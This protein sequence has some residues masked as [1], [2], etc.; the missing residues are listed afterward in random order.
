[1]LCTSQ[2]L[3]AGPA[4]ACQSRNAH[5]QRCALALTRTAAD[6][7]VAAAAHLARTAT[8]S[9][10]PTARGMQPCRAVAAP[11]DASREVEGGSKPPL[12]VV[13]AGAGIGGLV[14]AVGLLK[15]GFEVTVL[16]RDMTA[17][18][19]EGKYRGPIQIQSN[20]LGAL[21][22]LDLEVA[23][24][25][26]DVGCITGDRINGLC[27]GVTGD[28]YIKF[29]TFHPAVDMGLPVTRVISRV[30]L[31]EILA[32]ACQR[33]AGDGVIT[34]SVNIVD[35]EQ[36]PDPVTGK[37]VVTA[38]AEDGRRF[39]GDLLIGADGI[40]SKVRRK[41]LGDSEPNYSQYTCYTG[42]S[43]FTPADIDVVG[44]RVFLGNGKYFVSSDVGGGKMQWYAFHKEPADGTDAPGRCKHRLMEIFGSWTHL[45]TDLIKATKE[46]DI[47]RRDIY[48]RP[49]IFKWADGRVALLGDS[50]H[51]MQPNLGQG[52]CMAIE[53]A[54]QL[55]LDLCKEADA[56]QAEA[57]KGQPRDMDVEGVLSGYTGKRVV[58]AATIHGMAGMAAYMA[59]TY[60]AYLG[61]GLGPLSWITKFKIPH[62]GRVVGQVVMKATMP[63][64]MYGILGG[65]RKSLESSDRVA[66]CHLADQP[67]G[68]AE[69][70]F[71]LYMRDDDALLRAS[72][73]HWILTPAIEEGVDEEALHREF[74]AAK[75]QSPV[76]T[77]AGLTVGSAASCDMV[78]DSP[79][80]AAKHARLHQC[81]MG[82]YH[83]TDL[84]SEHGTWVNDRKLA[85]NAAFRLHP[86]D[87][88]RFGPPREGAIDFVVRMVHRSLLE[89][90]GRHGSYDR[91]AA[92]RSADERSV[93]L[94]SK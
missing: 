65:Y 24:R 3:A 1:M 14:L 68:F 41:M 30:T 31:Q 8:R 91:R 81:E 22:A 82:D 86:G 83:L 38:I 10:A 70:L 5:Q 44:Y 74:E 88:V 54:Y 21:E 29:D 71:P 58:R 9:A 37:Q 60:K 53:D 15:R 56:V 48:D 45:V 39:T 55:V 16:E 6:G 26:Y 76:I 27:D 67:Q 32:D 47:L 79:G 40:W 85:P 66:M 69:A 80:S 62:P 13:I 25:V 84:G 63:G 4:A 20:A 87:T 11:V 42:I 46:E 92:Q 77:K 33:V 12:K 78:L 7:G 36:G 90:G 73:A 64:T 35:Y 19:G 18:R 23:Q 57:S 75:H 49:P 94:S 59:S 28:W 52:G 2:R 43:D 34:N 50:A 89:S 93:A 51:A 17:I 72:H 61:E